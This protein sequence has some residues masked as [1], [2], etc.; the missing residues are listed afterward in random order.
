MSKEHVL[1][2]YKNVFR[3]EDVT[4]ELEN[5]KRYDRYVCRLMLLQDVVPAITYEDA[6]WWCELASTEFGLDDVPSLHGGLP[7]SPLVVGLFAKARC[8][9]LGQ[10]DSNDETSHSLL[11]NAIF[12]SNYAYAPAYFVLATCLNGGENTLG[13]DTMQLYL[14]AVRLYPEFSMALTNIGSIMHNGEVRVIG[15]REMGKRSVLLRAVE[16]GAKNE[17]AWMNLGNDVDLCE[18]VEVSGEMFGRVELYIQA[19]RVEPTRIDTWLNLSYAMEGPGQQVEVFEGQW[20]DKLGVLAKAMHCGGPEHF[21]LFEVLDSLLA[22]EN[23]GWRRVDH[24]LYWRGPT[25]VLF[26]T[27]L[28]GLQK[29]EVAGEIWPCHYST[30]ED[31]LACWTWSDAL[32]LN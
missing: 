23:K 18:T 7:V 9:L 15:G 8:L 27:L 22:S 1:Q 19:I 30:W 25:N 29:L 6:A 11:E 28:A 17:V 3:V 20:F 5:I 16:M 24:D 32:K 14:E 2:R 10:R 4:R 26:G 31:M 13:M 21:G 12:F